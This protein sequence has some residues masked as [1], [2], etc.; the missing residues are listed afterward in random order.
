MK[1]FCIKTNNT[2]ILNYLLNQIEKI[3]FKDLIYTKNKFKIYNNIIIHYKGEDNKNFYYFL[4]DLIKKIITEFYEEKIIKQLINYNYF[5]FEDHE[6]R[7]ILQNCLKIIKLDENKEREKINILISKEII[8]YIMENKTMNLNGFIYFRIKEYFNYLDNNVDRAVSQF[9][10]EKEY[11]EFIS[12]LRIYVETR[13][14]EYD[15]LHLIYING[16]S[17]LIDKNKNIVSVSENIYNAKYLSDIS[18]SSN[19]L[20]LNT[21]LTLLPKKIEIHLIDEED[22]FI[23]TIKLIFEGRVSLCKDCNIC[24]TYK[25]LNSAKSIH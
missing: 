14:T 3:D 25:L 17:I 2:K 7:I 23:N 24:R 1:S 15:L 5:Y 18:F 9:V 22:E 11:S 16:E 8:K 12:L 21:L 6:K 19:D 20:A 13:S 10:I 4:C